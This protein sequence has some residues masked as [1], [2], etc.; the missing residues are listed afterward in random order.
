MNLLQDQRGNSHIVLFVA[1]AVIAVVG[2][3]GYRVSSSHDVASSSNATFSSREPAAIKNT[4]DVKKAEK[5]L[6]NTSMDSPDQLDQDLN[7]L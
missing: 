4:A 7:A 3:V 1:I 6:D 5:S 2:V